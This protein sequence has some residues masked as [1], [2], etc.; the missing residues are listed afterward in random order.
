MPETE[1]IQSSTWPRYEE[2]DGDFKA[3]SIETFLLKPVFKLRLLYM[4][5][6]NYCKVFPSLGVMP[7]KNKRK[8]KK[9]KRRGAV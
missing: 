3:L 2:N 1:G 7:V 4:Y 5:S 6:V 8:K 9:K